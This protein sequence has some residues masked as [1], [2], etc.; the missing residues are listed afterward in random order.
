MDEAGQVDVAVDL[1]SVETL[2]DIRNER[3]VEHVFKN[4]ATANVTAQM[5][6]AALE[7]LG[8]G[9]DT[10]VEFDGSLAFLGQD[11]DVY[12]EL[13]ALRVSENRVL[14]TSND[15]LFL[16]VDELGITP[17]IDKLQEIAGLDGITRAVPITLRMMFDNSPELVTQSTT[18]LTD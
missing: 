6:M 15:M 14:V 10:V 7:K 4:I 8:I 1:S 3:M 17:G 5:D 11:V 18:K 12:T 9:E 16:S 13:Y 2:V